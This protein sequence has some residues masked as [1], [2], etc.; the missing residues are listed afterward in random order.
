MLLRV[1]RGVL[2]YLGDNDRYK[3]ECE[4]QKKNEES[5]VMATG[6]V[7]YNLRAGTNNNLE[8]VRELEVILKEELKYIDIFKIKD[9]AVFFSGLEKDDYVIIAG[10]DGT[11]NQF[12][13]ATEK[14]EI[15]NEILYYPIGTGNDFAMDVGYRKGCAPF[16]IGQYLK[17]LPIVEVNGKKYRFINGVGYGIDGYCCEVGDELKKTPGKKVNY[18]AIAIK[19]LLFFYK[20]TNATV[21]VDGETYTYKKVWLAPTM[22]GRFYGGGMIPTPKQ[23][24]MGA[25]GKLSTL[26]FHGSGKIRTLM[27]FPS[28]FKG[29][30]IKHKSIVDILEGK[31]I[32]VEFDR[33]TALQID[34]E[35]I[36][37][38]TSYTAMS[39]DN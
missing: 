25:E 32:T 37:G 31:K 4:K 15:N 3:Y 34:G 14:I 8:N 13:N 30:H 7:L 6:Y 35:T 22:Y 20:P 39:T 24:R 27:V 18:T 5:N 26:I 21:T 33:P 2:V 12:V 9:Y 16:S 36:L 17:N 10:G 38:V 29:E 11:L 1:K 28:I 19:G 23:N